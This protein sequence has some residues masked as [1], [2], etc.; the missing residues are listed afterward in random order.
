MYSVFHSHLSVS[1]LGLALVSGFGGLLGFY[2]PEY[3]ALGKDYED[4]THLMTYPTLFMYAVHSTRAVH[5]LKGQGHWKP[6]RNAARDWRWP[7]NRP[8]NI[9]HHPCRWSNPLRPRKDLRVASLVTVRG[10]PS[11]WAKRSTRSYDNPGNLT[12]LLH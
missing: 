7:T 11:C 12:Q 9:N 1:T 8:F 3:S 5:L 10:G 4:I 2:I 6:N